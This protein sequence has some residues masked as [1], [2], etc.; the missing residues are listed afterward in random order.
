MNVI[1][2]ATV[3]SSRAEK[4]KEQETDDRLA[5]EHQ[6]AGNCYRE[7]LR[8]PVN[9]RSPGGQQDFGFVKGLKRFDQVHHGSDR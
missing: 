7:R 1:T 4:G 2:E 9:S 5:E 3:S 6:Q 8:L